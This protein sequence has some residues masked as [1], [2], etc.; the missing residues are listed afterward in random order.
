MVSAGGLFTYV[1]AGLPGCFGDAGAFNT[2]ELKRNIDDGLLSAT[3]ST[4]IG[5][6]TREYH[7]YLVGDG[8]FSLSSCLQKCYTPASQENSP[9][10]KYNRAIINCRREVERVFGRLKGRWAFCNRNTFWGSP[11]FTRDA[12]L[13]CCALHNLLESRH[14]EYM[15]ERVANMD[16]QAQAQVHEHPGGNTAQGV[17][18]RER[19]TKYL[20][21]PIE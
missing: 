16:A 20:S 15:P 2:S 11:N 8:A 12:H 6:D 21:L 17:A 13:V 18:L 14:V 4:T 19:L 10:G 1:S 3:W 7:P 5:E 9:K